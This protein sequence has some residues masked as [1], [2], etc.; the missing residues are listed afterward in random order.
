MIG[1]FQGSPRQQNIAIVFGAGISCL[2]ADALFLHPPLRFTA[3]IA[4]TTAG[5]I[6]GMGQFFQLQAYRAYGLSRTMPL[7]TGIQLA[8]SGLSGLLLFSE[9]GNPTRRFWG[10]LALLTVSVGV[11]CSSWQEKNGII[12][13]KQLR[14]GLITT[15]I[16][17]MLF[18]SYTPLLRLFEVSA[19]ESV[20]PMGIGLLAYSVLA[21]FM[22]KNPK[23]SSTIS[24]SQRETF[25]Q[26]R[27]IWLAIA[28][29]IWAIGNM[30]L[31]MA[32]GMI[33]VAT[34]YSLSQVSVAITT[35][36][37]IFFLGESRTKKELPIVLLG[38]GLIIL[39]GV[40][41]SFTQI[42]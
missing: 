27:L 17:G 1:V 34:A 12:S 20:G 9:W 11:I 21:V 3:I 26:A 30:F 7:S 24:D 42:S 19:A 40:F 33:G 2:I 25:W 4:G 39:G 36:G 31:L 13:A 10:I 5:L 41:L 14:L 23:T 32:V 28:G 22:V 38:V 15:I 29:M 16:S 18:G 37:S 6:W 8:F 35:L